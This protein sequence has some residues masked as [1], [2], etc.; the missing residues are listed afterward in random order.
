MNSVSIIVPVGPNEPQ[1]D[2]LVASLQGVGYG[3]EVLFCCCN[4]LQLQRF[5]ARYCEEL[6]QINSRWLFSDCGRAVQMNTG[7]EQA[8]GEIL[9]FVH[10]DSRFPSD[11]WSELQQQLK[12]HP[13]DLHC[14]RL[15]FSSDGPSQLW[16]NA[17][18]AN[19]R[20]RWLGVPFGDQGFA[21]NKQYFVEL[22]GY[23]TSAVY[24]EDHLLVWK[25]R[26]SGMRIRM[27]AA[28]IQTSGR[29]YQQQGWL[30]LS[31]RYQYLW[32]RQALPQWLK[33]IAQRCR[34]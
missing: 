34:Q 28:S 22:G 4:T 3:T 26:Q 19:F 7:A 24:G 12:T 27:T 9:W 10:A 14:S 13:N 5:Q 15:Q 11:L 25:A 1:L 29:K 32:L 30:T 8:Q 17:Q 2:G 18:G 23:D 20:T 16:L 31:A 21:L 6:A 33:L